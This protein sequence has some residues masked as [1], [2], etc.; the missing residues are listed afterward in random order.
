MRN[1]LV[2]LLARIRGEGEP[3]PLKRRLGSWMLRNFPGMLSC[4]EFEDFIYDYHEGSL[5]PDVRRRFEDHMKLCPMCR[6][7]FES[8]LRTIAIGQRLCEDEER[9][10]EGMPEELVGAILQALRVRSS[11]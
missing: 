9:L 11:P 7:H 3:G 10:P 8:Y 6:V 2:S 1:V 5:P 4:I